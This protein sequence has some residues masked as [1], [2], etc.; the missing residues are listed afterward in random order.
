MLRESGS[1]ESFWSWSQKR[2]LVLGELIDFTIYVCFMLSHHMGIV[3]INEIARGYNA[4]LFVNPIFHNIAI[5]L[6][7]M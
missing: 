3:C 1:G 7:L 6:S 2:G 5:S 4:L